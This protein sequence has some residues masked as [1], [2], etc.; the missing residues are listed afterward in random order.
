M[1]KLKIGLF[2]F[3]ILS[4]SCAQIEKWQAGQSAERRVFSTRKVWVRDTTASTNLG[5]RKINRMQPVAFQNLI[6]SGNAIDSVVALDKNS[7]QEVWRAPILNG[8]E[9][10]ATLINDRL[11]VGANDGQFYALSA[12]TGAV[13]WT[14]PTRI[15]TLSEPLLEEGVLYFMTGNNTLYALDAATGKQLWLYSRPDTSSLSIRGGSRPAY[16][17]GTIYVGFSDG[18]VV[19]LL[20]KTGILKWEKQLNRNKKFRDLDSNPI[21]ENDYLY[22]IGFDDAIYC[23]RAAT[24]E[25]VW[26][27]DRGGY[28]TPLIL[29]DKL[30]YATSTNELAALN[31]ANG[32]KLWSYP[33][34]EG[35]ATSPA[36]Y[37]G[38]LV[39]G[40]SNG[41]LV[42]LETTKG[43]SIASFEPGRGVFSP[44]LAD[45]KNSNVYFISNE[46]N[47]YSIEAKWTFPKHISF[48]E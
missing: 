10:S 15:E 24:G 33:L 5:F 44:I 13:I 42:F 47:L 23:L 17:A 39:F 8:V 11:F 46:S 19:A 30:F 18:S 1:L 27:S 25:Q 34:H 21:I 9:A 4:L 41:S 35:I 38:L 7:G 36:L 40:E 48:L 43:K 16:R 22:L 32:E 20:A 31:K 28:G 29:G 12:K 6:I 45:E 37:K 14:F 3:S 26:R 2:V